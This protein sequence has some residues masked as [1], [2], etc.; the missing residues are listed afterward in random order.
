MARAVAKLA[1]AA[2]SRLARR[3]AGAVAVDAA[4]CRGTGVALRRGRRDG[5]DARG[6]IDALSAV[7]RV[8]AGV[9]GRLAIAVRDA[10]A[11]A[12]RERR[13]ARRRDEEVRAHQRAP[14]QRPTLAT[15]ASVLDAVAQHTLGGAH[16]APS[17]HMHASS[18]QRPPQQYPLSSSQIEFGPQGENGQRP[19]FVGR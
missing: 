19:P 4:S 14:G 17:P 18:T 5:A 10:A 7:A 13:E 3:G 16:P 6:S 15:H 11:R 8:V 12:G 9:G 1:G 2:L